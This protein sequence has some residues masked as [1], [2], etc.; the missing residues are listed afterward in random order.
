MRR[1]DGLWLH[2]KALLSQ[3][4]SIG[5]Y[6]YLT[7]WCQSMRVVNMLVKMSTCQFPKKYAYLGFRYESVQFKGNILN[8]TAVGPNKLIDFITQFVE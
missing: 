2:L 3:Q 1:L 8:V 6:Y 5:C 7:C 4:A